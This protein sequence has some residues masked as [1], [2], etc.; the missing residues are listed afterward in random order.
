[1]LRI[2]NRSLLWN[3]LILQNLDKFF[4]GDDADGVFRNAHVNLNSDGDVLLETLV[5]LTE[6]SL[7][8]VSETPDTSHPWTAFRGHCC[9]GWNN[10]P[11]WTHLI[12]LDSL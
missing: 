4:R 5:K 7:R 10:A 6:T 9:N 3:N 8:D 1:M 12:L 2:N 11:L